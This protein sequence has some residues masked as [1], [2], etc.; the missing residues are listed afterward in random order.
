[1]LFLFLLASLVSDEKSAVILI[2][3]FLSIMCRFSL[4][5]LEM[6][7]FVFSFRKFDCEV[8]ECGFTWGFPVWS[9]LSL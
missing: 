5:A 2:V 6:L 9:S 4:A 8:S 3:D 1:M 7:F